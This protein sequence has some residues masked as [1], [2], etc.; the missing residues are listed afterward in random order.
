L[1]GAEVLN[2]SRLEVG[3]QVDEDLRGCKC[4]GIRTVMIDQLYA[5]IFG[6]RF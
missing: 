3:K 6:D 4:I 2:A 1:G 5:E